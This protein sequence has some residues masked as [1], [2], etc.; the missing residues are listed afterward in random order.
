MI[1]LLSLVLLIG[2]IDSLNPSTVA[3]ALY[4]AGGREPH[5]GLLGFVSGVF[6]VNLLGGLILT[7]GP[8]QAILAIAP[9]PGPEARHWIEVALGLA[10]LILA[11]GLWLARKQLHLHV[12]GRTD[13]IDRSSLL[14]GAGITAAELPTALPYFAVIA[15]VVDSGRALS[16]QIGL[17]VIFNVVF[18]APLLGIW[19]LRGLAGAGG[20][21]TIERLRARLDRHL[22]TA[23]PALVLVI[24]VVL[25]ARGGVGLTHKH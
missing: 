23:I 4:F 8:G 10:T 1:H 15:A 13:R 3:P 21:E 24:S 6:V 2:V 19:A 12:S 7:V 22:A 11:G 5:R 20:K 25:L 16:T 14:V 9:R 18:V 17:I